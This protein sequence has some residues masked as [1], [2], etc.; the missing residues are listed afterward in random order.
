MTYILNVCHNNVHE[1]RADPSESWGVIIS[2]GP[3]LCLT[4]LLELQP[5][6]LLKLGC[7]LRSMHSKNDFANAMND[8]CKRPQN[9][10]GCQDICSKHSGPPPLT[11]GT[12]SQTASSRPLRPHPDDGARARI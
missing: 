11:L 3:G 12:P 4:T 10:A 5:V 2:S 8:I 1:S 6:L 9:S 7:E